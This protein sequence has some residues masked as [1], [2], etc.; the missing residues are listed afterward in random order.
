MEELL[1]N[2]AMTNSE[3]H[4]WGNAL[5]FHHQWMV[6]SREHAAA[7]VQHRREI[8]MVSWVWAWL[9]DM[10]WGHKHTISV[11]D[12]HSLPFYS[13]V[14]YTG[15]RC[16]QV[17]AEVAVCWAAWGITQLLQTGQDGVWIAAFRPYYAFL[18]GMVA[19]LCC[20][21]MRCPSHCCCAGRL[22][23]CCARRA[24]VWWL[25]WRLDCDQILR[26]SGSMDGF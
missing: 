11:M 20:A 24:A 2:S 3:A 17:V 14:Q 13:K 19:E 21:V 18:A 12:A 23:V 16:V 10:L 7:L 5:T 4:E 1:D 8:M 15:G 6:L 25:V 9:R 22:A 26:C